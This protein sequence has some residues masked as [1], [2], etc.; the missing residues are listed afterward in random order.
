MKR[1]KFLLVFV[2]LL[3]GTLT[4]F[5]F[6]NNKYHKQILGIQCLRYTGPQ[7]L[8]PPYLVLLEP[9]YWTTI[10]E[11]PF[12]ICNGGED[13][14]AI[15]FENS[16]VTP[17]QARQILWEYYRDHGFYPPN[18]NSISHVSGKVI[19]VYTKEIE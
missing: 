11:N 16:Q 5:A 6:T 7:I 2:F 9:A 15:C 8:N 3:V 18:G 19:W 13:I 1:L 10:V 12:S 17:T 14:C 4:V